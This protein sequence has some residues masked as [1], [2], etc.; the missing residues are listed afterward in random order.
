MT[1]TLFACL[2]SLW[3]CLQ[4][5]VIGQRL[6]ERLATTLQPLLDLRFISRLLPGGNAALGGDDW[7]RDGQPSEFDIELEIEQEGGGE[8]QAT[9][10]SP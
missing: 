8:Q 1:F 2:E 10:L 9:L 5:W 3:R 4:V 7:K 6:P